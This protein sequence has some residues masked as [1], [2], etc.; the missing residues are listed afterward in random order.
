M[1]P[2]DA[3]QDLYD[4]MYRL[5]PTYA[6]VTARECA[7]VAVD[8]IIECVQNEDGYIFNTEYTSTHPKY[9]SYWVQVRE[10]LSKLR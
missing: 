8:K 5:L 7:L 6:R 10:H 3:A 9:K 4:S 2:K 1:N